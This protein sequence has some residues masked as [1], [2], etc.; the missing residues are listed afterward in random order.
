M[1]G[2]DRGWMARALELGAR[3]AAST[4]PNPAVGCVIVRD[5]R[6]VGEGH[7]QPAGGNHAEIEALAAAGGAASGATVYVSLEPCSHTGRTAPCTRAL[8]DARVGRVVYAIDDPNP[9]V[10][11]KG[12]RALREAG[13]VVESPLL[14]PEAEAQNRGFFSR[15]RRGRPWLRVKLAASLDGRTALANGSSRWLTGEAARS[16]VHAWRARSSAILTGIGTVLADDP[17]LTARPG[18]LGIRVLQPKRV[19]VDSQLRTPPAARLLAGGAGAGASAGGDAIV[20]AGAEAAGRVE[21]RRALERAGARIE[22]VAASPRCDLVEVVARLGALEINSVWVEA[23]PTLSG[24]LLA[25]GL[26][27]E[28]ILYYAPCALGNSARGMFELPLLTSLDE[29]YRL[30][31]DDVLRIGDDFR[32]RARVEGR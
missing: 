4:D 9:L 5:G 16:D 23:G 19:V 8:I 6:V 1:S 11:G 31:V 10:A 21:R 17:E 14:A 2:D 27:D 12:A 7:T 26:V 32:V 28:L 20:F 22:T 18:E 30:G 29:R 13:I 3:G 24:A 15:M 25:A